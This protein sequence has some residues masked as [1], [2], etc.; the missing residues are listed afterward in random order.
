[1]PNSSYNCALLSPEYTNSPCVPSD[2]SILAFNSFRCLTGMPNSSY[3]CAL[4]SGDLSILAFNSFRYLTGMPNSFNC[5]LLYS[6]NCALL[7]AE[8]IN[9]PCIPSDLS[10]LAFN[11]LASAVS[12]ISFIPR[13]SLVLLP[14]SSTRYLTG[15]PNSSNCALLAADNSSG[16]MP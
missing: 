6:S 10:I 5:A 4:L 7:A 8:Y 14:I 12:F 2:L 9:S 1:M 15:M 13:Y 3:N 16:A 11:S